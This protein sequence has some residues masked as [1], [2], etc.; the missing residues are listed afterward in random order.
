[1]IIHVIMILLLFLKESEAYVIT[2]MMIKDSFILLDE[3]VN[4]HN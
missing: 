3:K 1:M 4:K 2:K